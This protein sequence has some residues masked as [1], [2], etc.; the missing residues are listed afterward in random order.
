MASLGPLKLMPITAI[1]MLLSLAMMD[2]PKDPF[3]VALDDGAI[4]R[5]LWIYS[6]QS[7][8]LSIKNA[9]RPDW[10]PS[11][12]RLTGIDQC[13][14]FVSNLAKPVRVKRKAP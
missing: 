12:P 9:S 3:E 11:I 2:W 10:S 7:S 1:G 13:V 4:S 6:R 14:K 5:K 8:I